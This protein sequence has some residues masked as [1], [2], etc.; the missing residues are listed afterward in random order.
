MA[1]KQTKQK[2]A[3]RKATKTA[4]KKQNTSASAWWKDKTILGVVLGI[5]AITFAIYV[6]SLSADFTNWDDP[7]YVM[8]NPYIMS[9]SG[10]NIQT[11]FTEPIAYNYHPLTML[12]LAVNYQ[13]SG[14]NPSSYHALNLILHL[15]NTFLVFV[16]IFMLSGRKWVVA[17]ICALLFGIHP[18]HVESVAWI[19]ERKDVL[20][21]LFFIGGLITWLKYTALG[22]VNW[23]VASLLLFVLSALSKPAAIPFP[24]VLIL[25]DYYQNRSFDK[26]AILDKI[27]FFIIAIIFGLLTLNAQTQDQAVVGDFGN[28][29][30]ID[31][32]FFAFYGTMMYLVKLV[33]PVQLS[34]FY[35]YPSDQGALPVMY[36]LSVIVVLGLA[37]AALYS[38]KRTRLVVFGLLF[39]LVNVALVLQLV[40]VGSAIISDRYT[41]IP[42]V[43]LFFI[44][45]M[46]VNY[47]IQSKAKFSDTVRKGV[48]A[49]LA[50]FLLGCTVLAYGRVQVWQNSETLWNDVAA[51]YPNEPKAFNSRG[52]Y[53]YDQGVLLTAKQPKKATEFFQKALADYSKA[54]KVK[55]NNYMAFTNR[56]NI[57]K[58]NGDLQKALADY[59]KSI[60]IKPNHVQ[61][62]I[63]RGNIYQ[64]QGKTAE[65]LA[66]INKSIKIKPT[67]EAYFAR[68]V[69][70]REQQKFQ[71]ALD[72][73]K[74]ALQLRPNDYSI[75]TNRGNVYFSMGKYG[76]AI[77]DYEK[78][79]KYKPNDV[80]A[81][82][83]AGAALHQKGN[84]QK[85]I[86]FL[87]KAI[88]LNPNYP[89]YYYN[90]SQAY[91]A[92][93]D[94]A[95]A[96]KDAQKAQS[97]GMNVGA[98]YLQ[99]LQ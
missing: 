6:P 66:D 87:N 33:A 22:K 5:L 80:M 11:M 75:Y 54:I 29:S 24:V 19:A 96:L 13:L 90:R 84:Y 43:G 40:S 86:E 10:E 65:A 27:P 8:E 69:I 59:N 70:Y 55:P 38:L 35:P 17:A 14:L 12:S 78:V 50:V 53:Y 77:Q 44:L 68:G 34:S 49:G 85:A 41:Y 42:Y 72:D 31:R 45:A 1:K 7:S 23:Y 71:K 58:Q 28:F 64:S 57:H 46:G 15:L 20:F 94:K 2:H 89:N 92:L 67:Y 21:G 30:I 93:G 18:M 9:L 37:A 47:V 99:G 74:S 3:A 25:L 32:V 52:N 62:L 91:N 4:A 98:D 48:L 56:G 60:K 97:L 63:N 73:Y 88:Q 26:K 79:L 61:G 16:F 95:K 83:N 51:K 36:Y 39:Y 76:K 82:G 81:L